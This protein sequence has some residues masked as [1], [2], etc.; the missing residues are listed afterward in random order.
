M[1]E[2]MNIRRS[3]TLILLT[4]F[5]IRIQAQVLSNPVSIAE[6]VFIG[7]TYPSGNTYVRSF[8]VRPTAV[9]WPKSIVLVSI[10]ARASTPIQSF[11]AEFVSAKVGPSYI[12]G[13]EGMEIQHAPCGPA[14]FRKKH[15][16]SIVYLSEDFFNAS[17]DHCDPNEGVAVY[18]TNPVPFSVK[19]MAFPEGIRIVEP[20]LLTGTRPL[21]RVEQAEV[22]RQKAEPARGCTTARAFMDAATR[23][24]QGNLDSRFSVRLSAYKT[25][26]CT[27]SLSTVYLLD[28]FRGQELLRTF[29]AS[30]N[31]GPQ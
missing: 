5:C 14:E 18:R 9:T 24:F 2:V 30:Q 11:E 3:L 31:H 23:V 16:P 12:P 17:F 7:Q 13:V 10:P 21:S 20:R 28:V 1:L 8:P 19:V 25:P 29:Q 15:D 22:A 6:N 27:G 26:G 4:A